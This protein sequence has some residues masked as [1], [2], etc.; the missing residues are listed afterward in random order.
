MFIA[1]SC[2]NFLQKNVA[3]KWFCN[4]TKILGKE[5]LFRRMTHRKRGFQNKLS[6]PTVDW[7]SN[8]KRARQKGRRRMGETGF[9]ENQWFPDVSC[10]ICGFQRKSATPKPFLRTSVNLFDFSLLVSPGQSSLIFDHRLVKE[11]KDFCW[12]SLRSLTLS[13]DLSWWE[14]HQRRCTATTVQFLVWGSL[15]RR[16]PSQSQLGETRTRW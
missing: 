9:S 13:E 12:R 1:F 15:R 7:V 11:G 14:D 8:V 4:P 3:L 2:P 16:R 6:S 10:E 5:G